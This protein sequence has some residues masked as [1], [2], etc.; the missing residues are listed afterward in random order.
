M[1]SAKSRF[2]HLGRSAPSPKDP[3]DLRMASVLERGY[4]DYSAPPLARDWTAM[5]NYPSLM[6][7]R[8]GCCTITAIGHLMQTWAANSSDPVPQFSDRDIVEAYSGAQG[9]VNG[10]PS[11]DRGGQMINA[12]T[13]TRKIGLGG[14][15]IGA[16]V[17]VDVY[18]QM[19]LEAA[20]NLFG[21]IYVG[22]RLP[23]RILTQD[24][25]ELRASDKM[26]DDD[27][28]GSLGGHAFAILGYD[29]H[30]LRCLPWR[31]P[32]YASIEWVKLYVDEAWA[33]VD[34]RWVT[35]ERVAPNGFSLER[36]G[37]SLRAIGA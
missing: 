14:L 26:T 12:L 2:G 35:G 25:W 1:P 30:H 3:R 37:V 6:N 4:R 24:N 9:Y 21:G 29:R 23:R 34:E 15:K 7:D 28:P 10:D 16:Y 27:D 17:R 19:E 5:P 31:D 13:W 20:I 36:L 18:D 8:L 11:T 33:I 32:V 22:A